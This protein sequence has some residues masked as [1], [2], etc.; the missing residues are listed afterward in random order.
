M[1]RRTLRDWLRALEDSP[2]EELWTTLAFLAG[3]RVELDADDQH[4]ALRRAELLLASGGDPHRTLELFGRAATAVAA[5]L[6]RPEARAELE[7]GLRA[8]EPETSGL[9]GA[10]EALRVLLAD[11]DLAWQCYAAALLAEELGSDEPETG[12]GT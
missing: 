1:A 5:D 11:A 4:A 8:L 7:E 10:Q 12:S 2:T 6:D 3:Q 9:R